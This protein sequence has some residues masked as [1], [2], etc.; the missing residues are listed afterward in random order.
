MPE[1][2]YFASQSKDEYERERLG[3]L[4]S[5]ADPKTVHEGW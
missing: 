2:N 3:L 5:V 1:R 4:E